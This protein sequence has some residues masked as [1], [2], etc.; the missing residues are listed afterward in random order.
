MS[1]PSAQIHLALHLTALQ[2]CRG[3]EGSVRK[4]Q[5]PLQH[6]CEKHSRFSLKKNSSPF[7]SLLLLPFSDIFVTP[8][9][10]CFLL[11]VVGS[12]RWLD[13]LNKASWVLIT[14]RLKMLFGSKKSFLYMVILPTSIVLNPFY[15]IFKN[16]Y[17]FIWLHRVLVAAQGIFSYGI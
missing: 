16:I 1:E 9:F 7:V 13:S 4:E 12:C 6:Q 14:L 10:A 17:L 11:P 5:F 2:R 8:P 15:F 3:E